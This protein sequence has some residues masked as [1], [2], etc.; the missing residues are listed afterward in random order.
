MKRI[1]ALFLTV[2]LSVSA[3][4]W[5]GGGWVSPVRVEN[6][7]VK[8]GWNGLPVEIEGLTAGSVAFVDSTW[9][10]ASVD[11]INPG[12]TGS[13]YIR[14]LL[15]DTITVRQYFHEQEIAIFDSLFWLAADGDTI[16]FDPTVGANVF[17]YEDENVVKAKLD[18]V[19][20]WTAQNLTAEKKAVVT[21]SMRNEGPT[22]LKGAVTAG[23]TATPTV[24]GADGSVTVGAT[25]GGANLTVN[26]TLETSIVPALEAANWTCTDGWSAGSGS[27]VKIGGTG[28]GTATPSGTFTVTAGITYKVTITC[29]A[30]G[31]TAPTYTLGGSSGSTI[32]A[33]TWT[34]YI[35][36]TTTA[37][38]IFSGA[39]ASTCTITALTV[40]K[41]TDG[42]GDASIVGNLKLSSPIQNAKGTSSIY[43]A[44]NGNVGVLNMNPS[45]LYAL[46]INGT[47]KAS[48]GGYFGAG[49]TTVGQTSTAMLTQGGSPLTG[50]L[51]YSSSAWYLDNSS[52]R[53]GNPTPEDQ[54]NWT[55]NI[56]SDADADASAV[57]AE[58]FGLK[59]H[60][61]TN[62]L[63][64]HYDF[65]STQSAGW[66]F[67][68]PVTI[69]GNLTN[70]GV[71]A[72]TVAGAASTQW[73]SANC[74]TLF[75]QGA[76]GNTK[77]ILT[78]DLSKVH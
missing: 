11:T 59:L 77:Y 29:S 67:D 2:F 76:T 34:D 19:G 46:D 56:S 45:V 9:T 55:L 3:F 4:A 42:T 22:R 60:T 40:Q 49:F 50:V 62:P 38:I 8:V 28:T 70:K 47:L 24:I 43:I 31:A 14:N 36:A 48:T 51:T 27:L 65:T 37:K 72:A 26:A 61:D 5:S 21:D 78:T 75:V 18:S 33:T 1:L 6:D 66:V 35:T 69:N 20:N 71:Q 39:A 64:S 13:V 41:L 53:I 44:P 10:L 12:P 74:D 7:T 63:L 58:H 54:D 57:T 17:W 23:A 30:V 52:W 68:K 25:T 15:V 73:W 16:G 32:T